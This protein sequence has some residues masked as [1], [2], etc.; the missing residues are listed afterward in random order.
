MNVRP[1][2]DLFEENFV[3]HG[4]LGASVSIWHRGEEVWTV[5]GGFEDPN[6]TQPWT[7]KT[8]VLI[9]SATKGLASACLIHACAQ[10]RLALDR[11]VATIWP[12]YATQGKEGTTLLHVLSHQAGQPALRDTTVSVFD[13]DG[14]AGA[15]A[16]Q[17]PFWPPGEAHGYH[18][19][20]YGFLVDELLRRITGGVPVAA[21]FRR[22]FGEPLGLDLWIGIPE[23]LVGEV[24]PIWAPRHAG[25]NPEENAFYRA[26]ADPSSLSRKAFST[27][28]GI[29]APSSMNDPKVQMHMF[30]SFGAIGTAESLARFYTAICEPDLFDSEAIDAMSALV[31]SGE[32]QVLRVPT[33]FGA[34]FM[35]DP[36]LDG[37]KQRELFGPSGQAFGQPG[38]GGSHAFADPE[39]KLAFAYVMNQM[40]PGIFPN[41]KSLRIVRSVYGCCL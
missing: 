1:L 4:E 18:A 31:V 5:A 13:H 29:P 39:N 36:V 10:H 24:A 3:V 30:P 8:R 9:W 21:Y 38:A 2:I 20:T 26:L 16:A 28:A 14:V 22:V 41:A 19:R 37:K 40:E 11:R 34:G 27:P 35:K 23:S 25:G 6:K 15:L 33:A 17:E 7:P 12:E 32:D